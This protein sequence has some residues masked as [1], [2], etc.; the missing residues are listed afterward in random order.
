MKQ[1][2]I[3]AG[4]ATLA[5]FTSHVDAQ[6]AR[7]PYPSKSLR[8]VVPFVPGG[9]T[10]IAGRTVARQL[11]EMGQSVIV[12]NRGGANGQVGS[13]L[14]AKAQP[15]G[16]T[17]L[18]ASLGTH[19]I[20]PSMYRNLP[21]DPVSSFTHVSMIATVGN[22]MVVSPRTQAGSLKELIALA[23]KYPG[24]LNYAA[25]GGSSHLMSELINSIAGIRT[26]H[27]PY[28]G[29]A[30]ATVAV[31]SGEVDFL[32]HSFSGLLP[33]VQAGKLRAI[34]VTTDVRSPLAPDVPTMSEAGLP[35]YNA[36][37][38]FSLVA[39][40]H[41]P[42][43]VLTRLNQVVV[44]GLKSRETVDYFNTL[45]AQVVVTTP[46]QTADF[47]RNEITKWGKVVQNAGIKPE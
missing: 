19:G 18:I 36:S 35:G 44:K 31:L 37:T 4:V 24:K 30:P 20:A 34:A 10:D 15:D 16:Y 47:L 42:P 39:P 29:A 21:Y 22:L 32:L 8:I 38:W 28:K 33:L 25:V 5:A 13:A 23:K 14:V 9:I 17:L 3:A 12:D 27:V 1:F 26:T 11:E 2:L 6:S 45:N 7:P 46:Q 41:T 43:E 40:A